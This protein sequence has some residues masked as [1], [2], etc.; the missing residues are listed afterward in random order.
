MRIL[1]NPLQFENKKVLI[2]AAGKQRARLYSVKDNEIRE[3]DYIHIET[4]KYSDR[5]GFFARSGRGMRMGSGAPYENKK[6]KVETDFI[7]ELGEKLPKHLAKFD[8]VYLFC[9]NYMHNMIEATFP[10][11]KEGMLRDVFWMNIVDTN[12]LKFV[13]IISSSLEGDALRARRRNAPP[14]AIKVLKKS[15]QARKV[16]G[17]K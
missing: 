6:Q 1:K 14:E 7:K 17:K 13:D 10:K 4:P 16:I 2:I 15:R 9:P 11:G 8:E 5:E 12:P 3:V